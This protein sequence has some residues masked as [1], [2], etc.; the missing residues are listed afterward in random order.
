M[1]EARIAAA[2]HDLA[3]DGLLHLKSVI[4][5]DIK[6]GRYYGAVILVARHGI[7]GLHEAIGLANPQDKRP[8]TKESVFS[9]FS[10][11]KAFTNLLVF[12]AIERGEFALTT[13]ISEIIP[14]FSGGRRQEIT[15]YHLL[16][17]RSGLPSVFTPAPGMYI[18]RLDEIVAAI[19]KN[20]HCVEEPG[21]L[22]TYSPMAHHA[23]L[24]EAVHRTDPKKRSYRQMV[25]D[26]LFT[27][28]KM[29]DSSIGVRK[30]LRARHVVPIFLDRSPIDHLGHSNLG[31]NGAFEEEDAEMPWVGGTTTV[32]DMFRFAEMLRRGGE[33][34]GARIVSP[35][36][37]DA[38]TRNR[39][40]D[41]PN[42]LYK[43]LAI[44][45]GW[46]A[47]PAYIGLGFFLRGEMICPHQFGTLTSPRT[48][49]NTGAGSTI[50]WVDPERDMTFVCLSAGVM[51]EAD[52][53][54][55]FQRLSDIA[56]SAAI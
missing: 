13:K 51:N 19:C 30:D 22:V 28:L 32:S 1:H 8:V 34:D 36:I 11:T 45:R 6:R 49:G 3:T 21:K 14:E 17:H 37:L 4:E 44:G 5:D 43:Q 53:I 2:G 20:V 35:A 10:V 39:T 48:F 15:V 54:E 31:P 42:E 26:E 33:L 23:L 18:D 9:L 47:Y 24:G 55:R 7:L 41:K 25:Q 40:G 27:P 12:R 16:T 29:K 56:V 38:A 52:N 50:F 46:R